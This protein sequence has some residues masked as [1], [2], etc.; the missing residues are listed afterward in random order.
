MHGSLRALATPYVALAILT[1][2]FVNLL[3]LTSPLYLTQIY[4][5]VLASQSENT[6]LALSILMVGAFAVLALFERLRSWVF[7]RLATRSDLKITPLIFSAHLQ[8]SKGGKQG[9]R[10]A[11]T[12]LDQVRRFISGPGPTAF[13]DMP[14]TVLY[15][16]VLFFIHFW[17][18]LYGLVSV[19][20]VLSLAM[21]G[22]WR[23]SAQSQN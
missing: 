3:Y 10:Q 15:L 20:L 13:L 6:L 19:L 12:D 2:L 23:Q 4:E 21:I 7:S 18:G 9:L 1:S 22:F 8:G 17:L 16:A 5:R 11:A 14:F